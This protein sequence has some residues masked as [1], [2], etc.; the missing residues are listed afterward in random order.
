M[1]KIHKEEMVRFLK[2]IY[3]KIPMKSEGNEF[4]RARAEN[5]NRINKENRSL[6]MKI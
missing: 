1:K 6:E 2:E 5:C 4:K 3:K